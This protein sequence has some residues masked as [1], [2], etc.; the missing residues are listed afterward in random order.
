MFSIIVPTHNRPALLSRTLKSLSEQTYK[1]F[2]VIIVSDSASTLPPYEDLRALEGHYVYVLRSGQ[3]GPAESRNLGLAVATSKY[4]IFLDDDDTFEP[5]HLEV[6][7]NRIGNKPPELIFCD[8][9]VCNEDRT[10]TPPEHL[11]TAEITIASVTRDSTFIINRIPN[12]CLAYRKDVVAN[13]S[14]DV[15]MIIYEDW[16]FLLKCLR[17]Y[18]LTYLPINS[19]VIHKSIADAP[20]N[21][22]RGNSRDDLLVETML[23][24]YKKHP[25]K[26]METRL[27]RQ[28]LMARA[29]VVVKLADC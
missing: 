25:V 26:K 12:S 14:F 15:N 23:G 27:E 1:N 16:D 2:V 24:L 20:E 4:V 21:M 22:R 29:G 7:A 6:L 28:A 5:G 8:F 17:K 18:S 19:V 11:S 10:K 13:I 9:K 3:A